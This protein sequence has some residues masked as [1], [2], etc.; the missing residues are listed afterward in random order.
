MSNTNSSTNGTAQGNVSRVPFIQT[1]P[2]LPTMVL[3]NP[4]SRAK[5]GVEAQAVI[6]IQGWAIARVKG[7]VKSSG[8]YDLR[9]SIYVL[10]AKTRKVASTLN[11]ALETVESYAEEVSLWTTASKS[12]GF[13]V[14]VPPNVIGDKVFFATNFEGDGDGG[15]VW[16]FWEGL[17]VLASSMNVA[18][19]DSVDGKKIMNIEQTHTFAQ[20]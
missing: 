3:A 20:I 4:A 8:W 15:D 7:K 10:L 18:Q 11:G 19:T 2:A 9:Y 12:D 1:T 17:E 14:E 13:D 16:A 5:N 6:A